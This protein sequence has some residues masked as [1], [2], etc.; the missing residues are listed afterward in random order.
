VGVDNIDLERQL[1]VPENE[2][3]HLLE[4]QQLVLTKI[5]V[6]SAI[7]IPVCTW[8]LIKFVNM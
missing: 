2:F 1:V 7:V 8:L 5:A 4:H 3:K 6:V